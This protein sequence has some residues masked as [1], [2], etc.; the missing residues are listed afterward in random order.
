MHGSILPVTPPPPPAPRRKFSL[1]YLPRVENL[2]EY[3]APGVARGGR[4]GEYFLHAI[5]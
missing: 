4:E 5:N 3:L 1:R 2:I